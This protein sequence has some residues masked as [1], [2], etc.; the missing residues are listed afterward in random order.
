VNAELPLNVTVLFSV[1]AAKL[2]DPTTIFGEETR[3]AEAGTAGVE[4]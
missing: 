2:T 3:V 1:V 4:T